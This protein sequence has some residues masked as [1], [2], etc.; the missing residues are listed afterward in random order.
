MNKYFRALIEI[1]TAFIK[2]AFI[3][4]ARGKNAKLSFVAAISP[5]A[6]MTVD[7]G[8]MISVGEKFRQRSGSHI[9]VRSNAELLIGKN[10]SINHNCMIVCHEKIEIGND[11]QFS[12]NV[13]IYDHDH[14]FRVN[15]GVKEMKYKSSPI[16]IGNNVWI[17]ANS[18]ILRGAVVGDNSVI[19]AGS[20]VNGIVPE[21]SVLVQ[22]RMNEIKR[23]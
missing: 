22:K 4:I 10:V 20:I 2:T 5:S 14:D 19:A 7:K 8:A 16:K 15:G 23:Y 6:E 1:P 21:N 9:R 12:P 3:K 11:V 13:M 17:G 18:V